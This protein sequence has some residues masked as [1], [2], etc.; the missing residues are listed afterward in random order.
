MDKLELKLQTMSRGPL[1]PFNTF[2]WF[3]LVWLQTE[4]R[5]SLPL[6]CCGTMLAFLDMHLRNMIVV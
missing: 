1:S 5:P 6:L 4:P 2:I 3:G